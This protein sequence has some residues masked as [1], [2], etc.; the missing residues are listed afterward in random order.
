MENLVP[1]ALMALALVAAFAAQAMLLAAREHVRQVWPDWFAQLARGG[2]GVRLGG[3]DDR[4]RR[5]LARPLLFG[6][7]E[8]PRGDPALSRLAE[9]FRLALLAV[10]LSAGGLV[11]IIALRMQTAASA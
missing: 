5:R 11:L 4:V 10:A 9:R 1:F 7:P 2:G 3:P 8:G 6:L